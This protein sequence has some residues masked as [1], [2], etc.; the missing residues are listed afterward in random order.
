MLF[1]VT[2]G[3]RHINDGTC[4]WLQVYT[5]PLI[6]GPLHPLTVTHNPLTHFHLPPCTLAWTISGVTSQERAADAGAQLPSALLL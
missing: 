4:G 1:S 2:H 6:Y 3:L 5:G